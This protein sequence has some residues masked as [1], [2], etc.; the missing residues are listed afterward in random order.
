MMRRMGTSYEQF[1]A[2]LRN[3]TARSLLGIEI[4]DGQ[5]EV[6]AAD[7]LAARAFYEVW[8]TSQG[9]STL[10]STRTVR[11]AGSAVSVERVLLDVSTVGR[12]GEPAKVR[13]ST[14]RLF[15]STTGGVS[16]WKAFLGVATLGLST[17]VT[18]INAGVGGDLDIPVH[19]V[20]AALI[21]KTGMAYSTVKLVVGGDAIELGLATVAS[22]AIVEAIN[23]A[24]SGGD[25]ALAAAD[26]WAIYEQGRAK[27]WPSEGALRKQLRKGQIAQQ[28]FEHDAA[29]A[30]TLQALATI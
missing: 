12:G 8:S 1:L 3:S 24:V 10:A 21:T 29:V 14:S 7:A 17:T 20:S 27:Q 30:R 2:C 18:G 13:V 9:G 25:R 28:R 16:A 22:R 19:A 15:I 23:A 11:Q 6:L 4:S 5:A 26:A